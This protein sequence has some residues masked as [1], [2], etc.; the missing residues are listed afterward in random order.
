MLT[1]SRVPI[2]ISDSIPGS[3]C[4]IC[5]TAHVQDTE[6]QVVWVQTFFNFH[7][8]GSDNLCKYCQRG[9]I[10]HVC[11][12]VLSLDSPGKCE[13]ILLFLCMVKWDM[14]SHLYGVLVW[15]CMIHIAHRTWWIGLDCFGYNHHFV[16]C[17]WA[18]GDRSSATAMQISTGDA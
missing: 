4:F 14:A 18:V 7:L 6:L 17:P 2:G 5:Q 12:L 16:Y 11:I 10:V 13:S 9:L 1:P 8:L 15:S 3:S